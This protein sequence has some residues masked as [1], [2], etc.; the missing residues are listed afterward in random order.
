MVFVEN[1]SFIYIN[2]RITNN[3][4]HCI[5]RNLDEFIVDCAKL[6][7]LDRFF[8]KSLWWRVLSACLMF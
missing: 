4:M 3:H 5:L 1:Y 7:D 6:L 8:K 2:K